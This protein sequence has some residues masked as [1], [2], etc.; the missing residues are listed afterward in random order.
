MQQS[1]IISR[2]WGA[3]ATREGMQFAHLKL[4]AEATDILESAHL[5][6]FVK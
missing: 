1:H 5:E 6:D 2:L 4:Q 3:T